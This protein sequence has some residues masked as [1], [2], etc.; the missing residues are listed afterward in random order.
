[1]SSTEPMRMDSLFPTNILFDYDVLSAGELEGLLGFVDIEV[2][3]SEPHMHK[4][5]SAKPLLKH[6]VRLSHEYMKFMSYKEHKLEIT[7]MWYNVQKKG[8]SH[9]PHTHS[10]TYLAGSFYLQADPQC[11]P[12]VFIDNRNIGSILPAHSKQTVHNARSRHYPPL[13]NSIII[14]PSWLQHFVSA[15]ESDTNRISVSFNV[16]I[17][18]EAGS[19]EDLT[20]ITW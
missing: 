6:I 3:H 18:G 2:R 9:H 8:Q 7:G 13:P 10:N 12:I 16:M 5:E 17:R 19:V 20:N 1:M 14:F 11:P 4:H 15:S